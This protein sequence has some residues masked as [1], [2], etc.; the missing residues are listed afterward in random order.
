LTIYGSNTSR[1]VN[2]VMWHEVGHAYTEVHHLGFATIHAEEH[3]VDSYAFC[4]MTLSERLGIS[5]LAPLPT[6]CVGY[7]R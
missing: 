4:H 5:F 7:L 2:K 6:S 1:I 3:W